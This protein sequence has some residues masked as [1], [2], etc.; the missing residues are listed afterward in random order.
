MKYLSVLNLSLS[1][2]NLAM[3]DFDNVEMDCYEAQQEVANEELFK[4]ADFVAVVLNDF[5]IR[6]YEENSWQINDSGFHN[7]DFSQLGF[8]DNVGY[9][10]SINSIYFDTS[11]N[12]EEL[13]QQLSL[14]IVLSCDATNDSDMDLNDLPTP[15]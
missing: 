7:V 13:I 6:N 8:L 15:F 12:R 1:H 2:A 3:Q 11:L 4:R 14:A 10:E 5:K 9:W